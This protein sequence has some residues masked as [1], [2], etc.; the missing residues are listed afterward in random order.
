MQRSYNFAML[1]MPWRQWSRSTAAEPLGNDTCES[2]RAHCPETRLESAVHRS[3]LALARQ[4]ANRQIK[5]ELAANWDHYNNIVVRTLSHNI[6]YLDSKL[7]HFNY[8]KNIGV[9][10]EC[11]Q[12]SNFTSSLF[13]WGIY[14][15][16]ILTANFAKIRRMRKFKL[17]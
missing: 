17:R 9:D 13:C 14:L 4:P 12:T 7:K 6:W 1:H 10:P 11:C 2:C 16:R 15:F 5:H 3:W 8:L